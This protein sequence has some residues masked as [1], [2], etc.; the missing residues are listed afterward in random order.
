MSFFI[1]KYKLILVAFFIVLLLF[2][3]VKLL[4]NGL[5]YDP[6][7]G[8]YLKVTDCSK[9]YIGGEGTFG[10]PGNRFK[11]SYVRVS[12]VS[13]YKDKVETV[14]RSLWRINGKLYDDAYF[15]YRENGI[16]KTHRFVNNID[17]TTFRLLEDDYYGDIGF[18]DDN[19]TY[20]LS[21]FQW[22]NHAKLSE[23]F[24]LSRGLG[25]MLIP[26][27]PDSVVSEEK[28]YENDLMNLIEINEPF[29]SRGSSF[30]GVYT[31]SY[32]TVN[33]TLYYQQSL[34][35]EVVNLGFVGNDA[36]IEKVYP[37]NGGSTREVILAVNDKLFLEGEELPYKPSSFSLIKISE[38]EA[39]R[40]LYSK[41]FVRID[42]DIYYIENTFNESTKIEFF[43]ADA[44]N[45]RYIGEQPFIHLAIYE[46]SSY[47]YQ[48]TIKGG[49]DKI[50]K[51]R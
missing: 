2:M 19:A 48:E 20:V 10:G 4:S 30:V 31:S 35:S 43:T 3:V 27:V 17:E 37:G 39:G 45:F 5:L 25:A 46:D 42:E 28:T 12:G 18:Q 14:A 15:A 11:K 33:G 38:N 26:A 9:S 34:D 6:L 24:C 29:Q 49:Y 47:T 16:N 8:I 44:T 50:L 1:K 13:W 7:G 41:D 40:P 22:G 21:R 36:T 23:G 32:V 51:T